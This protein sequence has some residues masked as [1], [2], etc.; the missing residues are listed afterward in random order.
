MLRAPERFKSEMPGV[1]I[2][3]RAWI[4]A[5]KGQI[6]QLRDQFVILSAGTLCVDFVWK[7]QSESQPVKASF[8]AAWIVPLSGPE[9]A[10]QAKVDSCFGK[11]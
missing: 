5:Y 3:K 4:I 7:V 11:C 10:R 1:E 9:D 6:T 8:D 2:A